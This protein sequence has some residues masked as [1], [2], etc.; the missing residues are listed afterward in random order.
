[1][2]ETRAV[3]LSKN[4][5]DTCNPLNYRILKITSGIYRKW[6]SAWLYKL[7][8]W[9]ATWDHDALHAGVPGKGAQDAWMKTAIE[10]ELNML[11]GYDIA[12]ASVD[13]FKCFDHI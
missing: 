9:V 8:P 13:V 3:F 2:L 5:D 12:G 7:A 10:N 11:L 1:M 6:A 4:P